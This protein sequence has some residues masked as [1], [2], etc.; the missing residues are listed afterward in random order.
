MKRGKVAEAEKLLDTIKR[1]SWLLKS[2]RAYYHFI[3]GIIDLQD[4]AFEDGQQHL[5]K[6]LKLGLRTPNDSALVLLNLAHIRLALK[7]KIG[8]KKYLA[9]AKELPFNDLML[10]DKIKEMEKVLS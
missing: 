6:S 2:H 7:D 10:K 5:E 3:K 1:P 4:K 9:E 8:S